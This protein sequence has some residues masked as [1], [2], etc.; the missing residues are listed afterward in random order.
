[1][2]MLL[3]NL[4]DPSAI[5]ECSLGIEEGGF[6]IMV[7]IDG[8]RVLHSSGTMVAPDVLLQ[9]VYNPVQGTT[10]QPQ[11]KLLR[12]PF[13]VDLECENRIPKALLL[14]LDIYLLQTSVRLYS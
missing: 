13:I 8:K 10:S 12:S 4:Y 3:R 2:D 11:Q 6:S 7:R 14:Q 9:C 1:M 5:L